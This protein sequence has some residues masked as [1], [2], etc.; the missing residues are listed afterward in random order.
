MYSEQGALKCSN[1]SPAKTPKTSNFSL[2]ERVDVEAKLPP[3]KLPDTSFNREFVPIN[4]PIPR[5]SR[6]PPPPPVPE[7][8]KP[9]RRDKR[10][11]KSS[12]KLKH[13]MD[14]N[15]QK[16]RECMES[17]SSLSPQRQDKKK[18]SNEEGSKSSSLGKVAGPKTLY[19]PHRK[20]YS[21]DT[22]EYLK[23]IESSDESSGEVDNSWY[24][25]PERVGEGVPLFNEPEDEFGSDDDDECESD[26]SEAADESNATPND[27]DFETLWVMRM[28]QVRQTMYG[29]R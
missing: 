18:Q 1:D 24:E 16:V 3:R 27:L 21:L 5:K 11:K 28:E 25:P 6:S 9:E 22:D 17:V 19:N 7:E 15:E 12:S 20:E 8:K 29:T 23:N 26:G 4:V 10:D 13:G 2:A 14:D